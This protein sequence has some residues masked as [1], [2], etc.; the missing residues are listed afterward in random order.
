MLVTNADLD[1]QRAD[2]RFSEKIT[3]IGDLPSVDGEE[4]YDAQGAMLIPGLH[5]H[6]IHLRAMSARKHSID[7]RGLSEAQ[8]ADTIRAHP[9]EGWLRGFGYHATH[10]GEL[11]RFKLDELCPDRPIRIQHSSGKMWVMNSAALNELGVTSESHE[12][13]EIDG[14]NLTGRLFRMDDWL[15]ERLPRQPVDLAPVLNDLLQVGVTS[16]TDTSFN[17]NAESEATLRSLT[18]HGQHFAVRVMGDE[19]LHHGG[20]LKVLLDEDALPDLDVLA[21]R[22]ESA[23]EKN[24][25][26]AFH[27]V[28]RIELL[29]AVDVLKRTG[30]HEDDRIE[31]G[32]IVSEDM[33]E[34]L[35][36]L[37]LPVVTQ[38]GFLV[39]RGERFR[40]EM[41][42]DEL[43]DLYR[44]KSLLDAGIRVICSSDAPYGPYDPWRCMEAASR[45][46]NDQGTV[47]SPQEQ[48]AAEVALSGYHLADNL[49][50]KNQIAIGEIANLVALKDGAV[51]AVW[52]GG[53]SIDLS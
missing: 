6:H 27:C 9:G 12:G 25:G 4:V 14:K 42:S 38:P 45:R 36:Q 13:V 20:Q 30:V 2:I 39:D 7:C 15:D 50:Q 1:G 33:I 29:V 32:A 11:D 18:V 44:Y 19:S 48:V 17:N 43:E 53:R 5:D 22:V 41:P 3:E 51:S 47:M 37:D 26:V 23:H 8:L 49:R 52:L 31:H 10:G 24:R 16:V 21:T 46:I 35:A 34:E 28:S 40:A